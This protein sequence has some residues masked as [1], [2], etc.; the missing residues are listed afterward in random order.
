VSTLAEIEAAARAL[1]VQEKTKL[2]ESLA[3]QLERSPFAVLGAGR[4]SGSP[5]EASGPSGVTV[6]ALVGEDFGKYEGVPD[7]STNPQYLDDFGL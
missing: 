3:A 1:S 5:G 2:L 6:G 7:L 4:H